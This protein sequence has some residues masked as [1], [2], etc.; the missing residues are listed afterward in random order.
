MAEGRWGGRYRGIAG[1]VAR[2]RL[3][4]GAIAFS[5]SAAFLAACGGSEDKPAT[6]GSTSASPGAGSGGAGGA[7]S[8]TAAVQE[9]PKPGGTIRSATITQ[10]PHFSPFHPGADPSYVNFWRRVGGYYEPL[11]N[12]KSVAAAGAN[13]AD[14]MILRLAEKVEQ[15]DETTYIVK[16]GAANFHNREPANGRKVTA[17]DIKANIDFLAKPPAS[18]GSFLQSGKDMRSV[19]AVDESTVRFETFGPRAFFYEAGGSVSPTGRPV[20]PKEMLDEERLKRSIPVGTGPYEYKS[21]SQ[22]SIE[23]VKRFDGY[24]LKPQ[25]YIDEKKLTFVPDNAAIEAAFRSGQIDGIGFSDIK[26]RDSVK[27]DLGARIGTKSFVTTSGMCLMVNVNRAPWNDIRVREAMY[28]ALDVD[29]VI[30]VVFFGDQQRSWY[31][32]PASITR[33]PVP[34]DKVKPF[35][36]YNP[37]KAADLLKASGIDLSKEYEFM[38][39]VETQTWVDAGKLFAEDLAAVGLKTRVNPVVRN[40]YLQRGGPKP[41]DFDITMSVFL[42]YQYMKTKSGTFWD[43]SSLQDPEIDAIVEKI[44]QTV[45]PKARDVLWEDV[46]MMLARKYSNLMPLIVSN[47]HY[48]WYSYVKGYDDAFDYFTNWQDKL[49]IDKA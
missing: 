46:Q 26:Q 1:R 25:P 36:D 23:E 7:T 31:F 10:A 18:G 49:W 22:G 3:L 28:R 44:E 48:G 35:V 27:K 32:S 4:Y 24:R 33:N 2:R 5:G 20:V 41:G 11:W 17:E 34:F 12:F 37:K 42:D 43:S 40:I 29:R 45:D 30:N 19:T 14:R 38:V 6:G 47:A 9:T 16:L 8:A 13:P 15:P 21:H 39:P